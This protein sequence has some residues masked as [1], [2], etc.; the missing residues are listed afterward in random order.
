MPLSYAPD[1]T[2]YSATQATHGVPA[3]GMLSSSL[4]FFDT[5]AEKAILVDAS[6]AVSQNF[7]STV[8]PVSRHNDGANYCFLDGHAKWNRI[9]QVTIALN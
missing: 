4:G 2:V 6:G 9:E 1:L 8:T 7:A 3:L 5:P